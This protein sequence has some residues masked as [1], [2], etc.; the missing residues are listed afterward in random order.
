MVLFDIMKHQISAY[1]LGLKY[2]SKAILAHG[3]LS[4]LK[5]IY[6]MVNNITITLKTA[7]IST[8]KI[9]IAKCYYIIP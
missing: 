9:R 6:S 4:L 7:L 5:Y 1:M 3:S 8:L 2:Y